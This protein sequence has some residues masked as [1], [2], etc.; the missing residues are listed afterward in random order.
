MLANVI[1]NQVAQKKG[2]ERVEDFEYRAQAQNDQSGGARPPDRFMKYAKHVVTMKAK[3]AAE[4]KAAAAEK[5]ATAA[6]K[7]AAAAEKAKRADVKKAV[8]LTTGRRAARVVE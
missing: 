2:D 7:K 1:L 4:K 5:K 6:E 3:R 8:K